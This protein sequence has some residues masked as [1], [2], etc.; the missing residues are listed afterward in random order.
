M[1]VPSTLSQ[2][3]HYICLRT[4]PSFY[5]LYV[6]KDQRSEIVVFCLFIFVWVAFCMM[7]YSVFKINKLAGW[8]SN[9]GWLFLWH[10]IHCYNL[11]MMVL[12]FEVQV[13]TKY[14]QIQN[15]R[16]FKHETLRSTLCGPM[17]ERGAAYMLCYRFNFFLYILFSSFPL[18][19]LWFAAG[20]QL[21]G[22]FWTLF[23]ST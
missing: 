1:E 7:V 14:L 22:M 11:S 20:C 16:I 10:G 8:L 3:V 6:E 4:H 9:G 21:E 19:R 23:F 2:V 13:A 5:T 17:K 18:S 12:L 15:V